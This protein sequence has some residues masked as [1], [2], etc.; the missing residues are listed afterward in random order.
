MILER[1]EG[2][3]GERERNVDVKRNIDQSPLTN[4]RTGTE[5]ETQACARTQDKT[6]NPLVHRTMLQT[7]EPHWLGQCYYFLF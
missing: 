6:C 7:N 4:A 3:E 5:A 1:G 2:R